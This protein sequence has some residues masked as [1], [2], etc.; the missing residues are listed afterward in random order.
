MTSWSISISL[1]HAPLNL[2]VV[3]GIK[4]Q[5]L[6]VVFGIKYQVLLWT[7]MLG[8]FLISLCT[9]DVSMNELSFTQTGVFKT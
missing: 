8:T 7:E 9:K 6:I 3:Y 4:Y 1:F 2:I 5:V